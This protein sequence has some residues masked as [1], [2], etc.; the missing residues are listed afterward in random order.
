MHG[1]DK[2]CNQENILSNKRHDSLNVSV[3]CHGAQWIWCK[4]DDILPIQTESPSTVPT[5]KGPS[6]YIGRCCM[7]TYWI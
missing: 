7:P 3:K 6:V 1:W 4:I 5:Q 2:I